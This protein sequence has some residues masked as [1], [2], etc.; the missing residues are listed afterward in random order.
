M[1]KKGEV[2]AEMMGASLVFYDNALYLFGYSMLSNQTEN[3]QSL[4]KYDLGLKIWEIVDVRNEIPEYRIYHGI[5]LYNGEMYLTYGCVVEISLFLSSVW[6]F[7]FAEKSWIL[8]SNLPMDFLCSAGSVQVGSKAYFLFGSSGESHLNS[9]FYLDLS[10]T[11]P[12]RKYLSSNWDS[13][14]K[15]KNHCSVTISDR[16]YIFGGVTMENV[17]LN[18]IWYFDLSTYN[19]NYIVTTGNI[20][21]GRQ[22]AACNT[23]FDTHI[24]VFGGTDKT[25]IYNDLSA[26]HI[27]T[28]SWKTIKS[29]SG[30]SPRSRFSACI[31]YFKYYI[32]IIGGR[33]NMGIFSDIWVYDYLNKEYRLVNSEDKIKIDLT[34]YKCWIDETESLFI[35]TI[36]GQ[37]I[38]QKPS[39]SVY[40]IEFSKIGDNFLTNSSLFYSFSTALPASTSIIHSGDYC[41]LLFGSYWDYLIVPYIFSFNYRLKEEYIWEINSNTYIY[42]HS[43]AHYAG[44]IYI[45]GGGY[46]TDKIQ[47]GEEVSNRFLKLTRS[48]IFL[49]TLQCSI[50]TVSPDCQTCTQGYY[51]NNDI[52]TP[53]PVGMYSTSIAIHSIFGCVPCGFG[54]YN[55]K[56]G[57]TYCINCPSDTYC[58]IGSSEL[59]KRSEILAYQNSQPLKYYTQANEI[60]NFINTLWYFFGITAFGITI[61]YLAFVKLRGKIHFLDIFSSRHSQRLYTPIMYRKTPIGGLFSIF[62]LLSAAITISGLLATFY[63]NNITESKT[64]IPGLLLEENVTASILEITV[65]FY[66]YTQQCAENSKC[67]AENSFLEFGFQFESKILNCKKIGTTCKIFIQYTGFSI[68]SASNV[69]IQMKEISVSATAITVN[70]SVSSSIPNEKSNVFIPVFTDSDLNLFVGT[71]PTVISYE[72]TPSVTFNSDFYL[73]KL[74][75]EQY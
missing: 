2:P 70:I 60:L 66:L 30:I 22:L 28:N 52:C 35:Y 1:P 14:S 37:T 10:E 44:S 68:G 45:F 65:F 3:L 15:R 55:P 17:H 20:P 31:F 43:A 64:L 61:L 62:F 72:F 9:V 18:D 71:V 48:D 33:D 24:I 38:S 69:K 6:K 23:V 29:E 36:G 13:P 63:F 11:V 8:V 47:L 21:A 49:S 42:G 73:R 34:G 58:P 46:S 40:R 7:N 26:Y 12:T 25:V 56:L 4:Y 51:A 54:N 67:I 27:N 41:Y 39:N 53:C 74:E 75:M 16:I 50:S 57:S 59:T 32:F 19:W 5:F